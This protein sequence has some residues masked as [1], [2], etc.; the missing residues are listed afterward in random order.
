MHT[1]SAEHHSLLQAAADSMGRSDRIAWTKERVLYWWRR[2]FETCQS[3][4]ILGFEQI[5]VDPPI[6]EFSTR[7]RTRAGEAHLRRNKVVF[8]MHFLMRETPETYDRTIGH[9]VAHIFAFRIHGD[10]GHG[11]WWK[12]TMRRIGLPPERCHTYKSSKRNAK[13]IY[14]GRCNVCGKEIPLTARRAGQIKHGSSIYHLVCGRSSRFQL[15]DSVIT[16]RPPAV[17]AAQPQEYW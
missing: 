7:M 8:A 4:N 6:V 15:M 13:R 14:K 2:C 10:C 9:E 1:E 16:V 11:G 12:H 3:T 17:V 5:R